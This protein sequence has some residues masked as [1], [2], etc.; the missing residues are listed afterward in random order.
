MIPN[1]TSKENIKINTQK[2]LWDG[3][4]K[5][6]AIHY[7]GSC[8]TEEQFLKSGK[9]DYVKNILEDSLINSKFSDLGGLAV[10]DVG[11][12]IGRLTQFMAQN[13]KK[14]IGLDVSNQM[15]IRAKS[16]LVGYK[17]VELFETDGES[18]PLP[19]NSIDLCFSI[20]VFQHIKDRKIVEKNF[21]DIHRVLK[22]NGLFKILISIRKPEKLESWWGGVSYNNESI[23]LLCKKTGF[24]LLKMEEYVKGCTQWLWLEKQT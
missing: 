9:D 14:A 22:Q 5:R 21:E 10:L 23:E 1:E 3:L 11:C 4:G 19:D 20:F 24:N 7:V 12:G 15:I 6:N 17:N 13:F 2:I 18:I 8:R 16:R